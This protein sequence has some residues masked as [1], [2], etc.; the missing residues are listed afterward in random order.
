MQIVSMMGLSFPAVRDTIDL[1]EGEGW[2][3]IRPTCRG[4]AQG[5][6]RTLTPAQEEVIQRI[7]NDK[8]PEQ[9][10]VNFFLWSCAAVGQLIEQEYG[11]KLHVRSIGKYLA[12]W[13]APH[14]NRS[15]ALMNKALKQYR[16][17]WRATARH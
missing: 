4:R 10:K 17:G 12:R 2:T 13:G 11:I 14:K 3:A 9:L 1:F 5:D 15:S 8:R 7:L 6:G 16:P